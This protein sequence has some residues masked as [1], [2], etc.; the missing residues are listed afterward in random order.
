MYF[1]RQIFFRFLIDDQRF[2]DAVTVLEGCIKVLFGNEDSFVDLLYLMGR[3][4]EGL[5]RLD[6]AKAWYE[7][8]VETD[9]LHRDAWDRLK[10]MGRK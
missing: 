2:Y 8:T 5:G 7:Q 1:K 10:R 3:A 4:H 9:R 6:E